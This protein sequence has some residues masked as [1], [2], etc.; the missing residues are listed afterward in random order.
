MCK[1]LLIL[2][3]GIVLAVGCGGGDA[4]SSLRVGAASA[5]VNPADGTYLA[6]YGQ[7]R[8]STGVHDD[9]Y[10]KAVVFDDGNTAVA[11][12]VIDSIGVQYDTVQE[13]REAASAKGDD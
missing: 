4:E 11:L 9:L 13:I 10:A 3:V 12:V 6:G 2:F 8:G 7:D 5:T 1:T